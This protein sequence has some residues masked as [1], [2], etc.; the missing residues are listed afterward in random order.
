MSCSFRP[1]AH[2]APGAEFVAITNV[3]M[4]DVARGVEERGWTVVTEGD[5]ITRVGSAVPIPRGAA[6]VDGSG[7]FLIPG[8]WDMHSHNQ[9]SGIGSLDLFLVNSVIGTRD[10][11]SDA[12]F[13]LP[14]RDRIRRGELQ[15]PDIVAAGPI[16]DDAPPE[17]PFR[18]RVRNAE[19]ARET[20]RDL[21]R[22][23]VDFIKVTTTHRATFSSLPPMRHGRWGC[24]LPDMSRW[25]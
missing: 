3:T 11:G 8:L 7:K 20:V 15:G 25:R 5:R 19:E 21:K 14:L 18:R 9:G 10:M 2:S 16:L 17:Y 1:P 13:I 23:G 12:D 4:I 6:R 22:Q 24:P